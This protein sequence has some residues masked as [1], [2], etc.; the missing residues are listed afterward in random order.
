MI[1]AFI[2]KLSDY[3]VCYIL[4]NTEVLTYGI[5]YDLLN[6]KYISVF[7]KIIPKL[8]ITCIGL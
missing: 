6:A 1:V 2:L 5:T 7:I 3:E 8:R 4:E